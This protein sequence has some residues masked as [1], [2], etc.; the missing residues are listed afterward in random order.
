M[1]SHMNEKNTEKDGFI[2][3]M[4]K[5]AVIIPAAGRSHRMRGIDKVFLDLAGRPVLM[6]TVEVF[7]SVL[8]ECVPVIVAI[9]RRDLL[10]AQEVLRDVSHVSVVA[11]GESR[12][13]SV[14]N[15]LTLVDE[16]VE[17]V[18]VHDGARPLLKAD[19]LEAFVRRGLGGSQGESLGESQSNPLEILEMPKMPEAWMMAVP[20]KDTV[21]RVDGNGRVLQTLCREELWLAQTPQ[22]FKGALL[23]AVHAEA[24]AQGFEGT[25]EAALV[26]WQGHDVVVFQGSYDNIKI[27]TP[28][29]VEYA[30][31]VLAARDLE[32]RQ[33]EVS[34]VAAEKGVAVEE[35]H[36]LQPRMRCGL[37]YDMHVLV[38]GRLLV[39]GGVT[40]PCERGLLGHSDADVLIH[41]LIDALLGALALGDIGKI[42]PDSDGRYQDIS[43]IILLREVAAMVRDHG[44]AVS[45]I[46]TV[47]CAQK[48]RLSPYIESMRRNLAV[49]LGL[50]ADQIS[51][52]ATTTEGL[53]PEGRGEGIS[54]QAVVM[55]EKEVSDG[56]QR[57]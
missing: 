53:G 2:G 34:G 39:L 15:A 21:K 3:V 11:G 19:D 52:K 45:H 5:I 22:M 36:S 14:A 49:C 16:H 25:D 20:V 38:E 7:R 13:Q 31:S 18:L 9:G 42:F 29:D 50:A 27:T 33:S 57:S 17:Y 54:A 44:Y 1:F 41:S 6:R 35:A 47:I 12:Q 8:G 28:E 43:S 37:G 24:K 46:D 4:A 48:P 51:V 30:R 26:E 10:R 32:V 40:I 23:R 56:E 55:M